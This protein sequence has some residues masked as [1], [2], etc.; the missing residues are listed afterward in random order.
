MSAGVDSGIGTVVDKGGVGVAVLAGAVVAGA[1][2]GIAAG[3]V[4]AGAFASAAIG[5]VAA[6]GIGG[7]GVSDKMKGFAGKI[8]Q[9]T[10][11]TLR[12]AGFI[13]GIATPVLTGMGAGYAAYKNA[14]ADQKT[15]DAAQGKLE[16]NVQCTQLSKLS[17]IEKGALQQSFE[18]GQADRQPST[19]SP[20]PAQ[21]C[22]LVPKR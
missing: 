6:V 14:A 7:I 10:A 18:T 19:L 21:K 1:A 20:D 4:A 15:P 13:M 16:Q 3:A 17:K 22:V 12:R 8:S 2:F 5:V 9:K 11:R